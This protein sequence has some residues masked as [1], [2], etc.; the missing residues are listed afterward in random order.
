M[1]KAENAK[2]FESQI[3]VQPN[4]ISA[5]SFVPG[6]SSY[7]QANVPDVLQR[8]LQR[9]YGKDVVDNRAN[10]RM[11]SGSDRLHEEMVSQQYK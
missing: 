3:A 11:F 2:T 9:Q 6:F 5:M 8:Q 10:R 4:V 1:K 7:A